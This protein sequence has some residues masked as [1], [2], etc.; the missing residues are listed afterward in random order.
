MTFTHP[1]RREV[2]RALDLVVRGDMRPAL[3][4][5]RRL[6]EYDRQQRDAWRRDRASR[7]DQLVL[8]LPPA[9]PLPPPK[10][11]GMHP[12]GAGAARRDTRLGLKS[13]GFPR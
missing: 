12:D 3:V 10:V 1:E 2:R 6:V 11:L 8:P 7:L 9:Y 4:S 5:M 13:Q